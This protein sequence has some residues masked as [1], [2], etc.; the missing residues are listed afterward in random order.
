MAGGRLSSTATTAAAASATP[1]AERQPANRR[2]TL[3]VSQ[4]PGEDGLLEVVDP[5]VGGPRSPPIG[6]ARAPRRSGRGSGRGRSAPG[7]PGRRSRGSRR[8]GASR[9]G[10]ARAGRSRYAGDLAGSGEIDVAAAP[11]HD[12]RDHVA[13]PRR[14]V[15]EQSEHRVGSEL[16]AELFVRARAARRR[17]VS[18]GSIGRPAAPTA[19]AWRFDPRRPPTQQERRPAGDAVHPPVEA[20]GL[21][22]D[23]AIVASAGSGS[24]PS[25]TASESTTTTATAACRR[26]SRTCAS[27]SWPAMLAAIRSRSVSS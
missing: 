16:E 8:T 19:P 15:V 23:S 11:H 20:G 12:R 5:V 21:A 17:P 9:R 22:G 3:S 13:G 25:R 6:T 24:S 4:R 27:R 1:A 10:T 18:P 26:S 7:R 14:V 2:A